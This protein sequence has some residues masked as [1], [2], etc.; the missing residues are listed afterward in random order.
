MLIKKFFEA[1]IFKSVGVWD[2][3]G[4][5]MNVIWEAVL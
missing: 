4:G 2:N 1:T 5:N 3:E